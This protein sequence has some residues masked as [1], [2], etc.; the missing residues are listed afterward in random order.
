MSNPF[1]REYDYVIVGGGAIGTSTA[2]YLSQVTSSIIVLD[3]GYSGAASRDINKIVR[4][5]YTDAFY[6]DLAQE[7]MSE[8]KSSPL[9]KGYVHPTGRVSLFDDEGRLSSIRKNHERNGL[10]VLED[11]TPSDLTI[12]TGGSVR[13][14]EILKPG[15]VFNPLDV[16][17]N[18]PNSVTAMR[19]RAKLRGVDF[20]EDEVEKLIFNRNSRCSGI[21]TRDGIISCSRK[22]VVATG[23]W[24]E[25]LLTKSLSPRSVSGQVNGAF[26]ISNSNVTNWPLATGICVVHFPL[27]GEN[28]ERFKKIP[29]ISY[30]GR[31]K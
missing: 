27:D 13:Y 10:S 23:A 28:L 12:K 4:F 17:V 20:I 11:L 3:Q 21:K 29:I 7:A 2:Y 18:Y 15:V 30:L 16:W 1:A 6:M 9:F 25:K 5:D 31:G 8:W 24:T 19:E 22:V 26:D 14:P